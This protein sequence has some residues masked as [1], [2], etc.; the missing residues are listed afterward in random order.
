MYQ[1]TNGNDAL[2]WLELAEGTTRD[3]LVERLAQAHLIADACSVAHVP[4]GSSRA[5]MFE[6]L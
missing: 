4:L 6:E 3:A 2:P 1:K 5:G